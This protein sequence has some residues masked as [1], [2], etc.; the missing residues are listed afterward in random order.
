MHPRKTGL[1]ISRKTLDGNCAFH[2]RAELVSQDVV[3]NRFD[4]EL[5]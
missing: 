4:A 5:P 2:Q 1:N 3:D